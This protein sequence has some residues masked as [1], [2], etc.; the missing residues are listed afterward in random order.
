[1]STRWGSK[2]P[3]VYLPGERRWEGSIDAD[4]GISVAPFREN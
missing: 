4:S 3:M 2:F 1:M